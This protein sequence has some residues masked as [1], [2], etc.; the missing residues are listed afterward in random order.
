MSTIFHAMFVCLRDIIFWFWKVNNGKKLASYVLKSKQLVHKCRKNYIVLSLRLLIT[1]PK[2]T[3]NVEKQLFRVS[4]KLIVHY[5]KR[6][7]QR[8]VVNEIG[9]DT[10]T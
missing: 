6:E 5:L 3:I 9:L 4:D 1:R 2:F 8:P 10:S 7:T